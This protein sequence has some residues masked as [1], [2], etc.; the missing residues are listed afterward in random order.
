L[1]KTVI[2]GGQDAG[3]HVV[4]AYRP[5]LQS[6]ESSLQ[7]LPG[8]VKAR[9]YPHDQGNGTAFDGRF[10]FKVGAVESLVEVAWLNVHD[11]DAA[12]RLAQNG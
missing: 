8:L 3:I 9:A 12:V 1:L 7:H 11:L 5:P 4:A 10:T 6:I 2:D